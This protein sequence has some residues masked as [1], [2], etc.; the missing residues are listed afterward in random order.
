MVRT[1]PGAEEQIWINEDLSVI[2]GWHG[3]GSYILALV[4]ND[5]GYS[6]APIPPSP[7]YPGG[8]RRHLP[9]YAPDTQATGTDS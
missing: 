2:A 8:A 4:R 1:S 6:I 3:Q 5:D 9:G 7:G